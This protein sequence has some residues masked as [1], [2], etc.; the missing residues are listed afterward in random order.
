[1]AYTE[2]M[3]NTA[4]WTAGAERAQPQRLPDDAV[5]QDQLA[6]LI[7]SG[8][9]L[10]TVAVWAVM[11]LS[12]K[13]VGLFKSV[14]LIWICIALY[15]RVAETVAASASTVQLVAF[16]YNVSGGTLPWMK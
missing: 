14:L 6:A 13:L 2:W 3:T 8:A 11:H 12:S 15:N 1:M 7:V 10:V 9:L 4:W 16:L 5:S